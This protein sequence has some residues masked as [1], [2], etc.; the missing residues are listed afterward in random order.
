[1][2]CDNKWTVLVIETMT[3]D[4]IDVSLARVKVLFAVLLRPQPTRRTSWKL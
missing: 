4:L 3:R 1:V 2:I